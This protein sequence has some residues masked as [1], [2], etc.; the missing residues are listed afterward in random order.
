MNVIVILCGIPE[1]ARKLWELQSSI[2]YFNN[3]RSA[4][5]NLNQRRKLAQTPNLFVG[6]H[7]CKLQ[8]DNDSNRCRAS[9]G[10]YIHD[11]WEMSLINK[12]VVYL[13]ASQRTSLIIMPKKTH[14]K[15]S[16]QVRPTN[17]IH[18]V[19]LNPQ[20]S[21]LCIYLSKSHILT[22]HTVTDH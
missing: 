4:R 5:Y 19:K 14:R 17:Y 13:G 2:T 12:H 16:H 22:T 15:E 21:H 18:R 6:S 7:E 9:K 1:A 20:C 8:Q 10:S 3:W 11:I